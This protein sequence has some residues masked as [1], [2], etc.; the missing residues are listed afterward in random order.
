[1]VLDKKIRQKSFSFCQLLNAWNNTGISQV[2]IEQVNFDNIE[3]YGIVD[4]SEKK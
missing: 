4:P 3:K 1:L 2:M